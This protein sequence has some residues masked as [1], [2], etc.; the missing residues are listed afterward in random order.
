MSERA[1][2]VVIGAGIVGL[3]T[4]WRLLQEKP[5][6]GVVVLEK[7][8]GPAA[9]QSGRNSGVLHSGIYYTPGSAKAR[10]CRE[11]KALMEAFCEEQSIDFDRCG[12]VIVALNEEELP[13]L[14]KIQERGEANGVECERIGVERLR[15]LEP[16][17]AGIAALHV[18]EAGIVDYPAVCVRLVELIREGGGEVLFGAKVETMFNGADAAVVEHKL[19]TTRSAQ[20]INCGGLHNDRI[21]GLAGKRPDARVIPFRGEYFMLREDVRGLCRNLIYPVPDPAFPFLGVHFTR[22]VDG[23]VECGPNAVLALAREGYSWSDISLRDLASTFSY[24]GFWKMAGKHW[25]T[26]MGEVHRSL[27]RRAFARALAHLVPEI[28]PEHLQRSPAGVRAQVVLPNG[29]MQDDFLFQRNGRVLNVVNAPSPA[30]TSA[31]A[32]G[33]EIAAKV[34]EHRA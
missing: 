32:I 10:N 26:G 4:A 24:G 21:A 18:P 31:L 14:D 6:C 2:A 23:S 5:G 15:E 28:Q 3:S 29:S 12:K 20:V 19:G 27:S 9:H 25:R 7:E 17:A 33:R 22:R 11:G 30:A 34:A 1:D 16:H 8:D 13:R